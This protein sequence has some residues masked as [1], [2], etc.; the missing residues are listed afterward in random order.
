MY[1][2]V[3][4][5]LG[6]T[7]SSLFTCAATLSLCTIPFIVLVVL[8][9]ATMYTCGRIFLC[10]LLAWPMSPLRSMPQRSANALN[11]AARRSFLRPGARAPVLTSF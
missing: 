10:V 9:A 11:T 5:K 1:T 3:P 8:F 7:I 4:T 6:M 2:H